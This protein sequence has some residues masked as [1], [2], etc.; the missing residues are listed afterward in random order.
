MP[1]DAHPVTE[2]TGIRE[3]GKAVE[4]RNNGLRQEARSKIEDRKVENMTIKGLPLTNL[5]E[6]VNG[7]KGRICVVT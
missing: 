7:G 1:T 3:I 4:V 6:S 2:S 5:D